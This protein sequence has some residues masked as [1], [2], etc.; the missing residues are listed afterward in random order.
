MDREQEELKSI[1]FWGIIK[2]T[3]KII[4]T[5]KKMFTKITLS[6]IL[7]LSI[8]LLAYPQLNDY[9]SR[10]VDKTR[11][12]KKTIY[13]FYGLLTLADIVFTLIIFLLP[14]SAIVYTIASIYTAKQFSF[15]TVLNVVPNVWKMLMVTIAVQF[16]IMLAYN[17]VALAVFIPL[18]LM[19]NGY[20]IYILIILLVLYMMGFVYINIIW[21]LAN[22]VTVLENLKGFVAMKKSKALLKG[23][24]LVASALFVLIYLPLVSVQ[25]AFDLILNF[26]SLG[27]VSKVGY[28]AICLLLTLVLILL[29]LVIQTIVYFVCKSFHG[30]TIDKSY[31][32][33]HLEAFMPG[34][35]PAL[36]ERNVLFQLEQLN[37]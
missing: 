25:I 18:L 13:G 31:L 5:W 16:L 22:V 33:N 3:C 26:G 14:T 7:P 1:G 9:I 32:A 24:V 27:I 37:I 28:G 36:A 19:I 2:E 21:S 8:I 12:G 30:E 20:M 11:G 4:Y 10:K 15:K 17:C 29:G 6:F 23:K 34:N 35:V